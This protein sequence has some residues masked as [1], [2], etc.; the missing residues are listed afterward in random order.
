MVCT[1]W[2]LTTVTVLFE[3]KTFLTWFSI[4]NHKVDLEIKKMKKSLRYKLKEKEINRILKSIILILKYWYLYKKI[5]FLRFCWMD[6][7]WKTDEC[8]DFLYFLRKV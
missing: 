4:C 2:Y 3:V 8:S 7:Y 6:D 5:V 1:V